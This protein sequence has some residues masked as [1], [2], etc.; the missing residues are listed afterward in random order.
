VASHGGRIWVESQL[1]QGSTFF[2]T[3]PV[4]SMESQIAAILNTPHLLT[5]F[6]T[7]F[8]VELSHM[9]KHPLQ[10]K[11]DQ[12]VLWEAWNTIQSTNLIGGAALLP[13]MFYNGFREVFFLV[14]CTNQNDAQLLSEQI[15]K[16]LEG[17]IGLQEAG[18]AMDVSFVALNIPL[19]I[20]TNLSAKQLMTITRNIQDF[21]KTALDNGVIQ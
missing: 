4:F 14:T 5:D 9:D 15:R 17:C 10:R 11:S 18:I 6:I 8:T 7:I 1:G 21:M 19:N 20:N 16:R 2:F 13:R 3:I 12:T